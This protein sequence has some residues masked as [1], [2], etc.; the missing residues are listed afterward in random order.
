MSDNNNNNNIDNID[1][2]S[3]NYFF[4]RM[5]R[6]YTQMGTRYCRKTM[7]RVR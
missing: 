6:E 7:V 3:F 4:I 5:G 2:N 1:V